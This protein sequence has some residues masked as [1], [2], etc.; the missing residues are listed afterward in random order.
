[1]G[2]ASVASVAEQKTVFIYNECNHQTNT[3]CHEMH[4]IQ[5]YL[6]NVVKGRRAWQKSFLCFQGYLIFFHF[7]ILIRNLYKVDCEKWMPLRN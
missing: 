7:L 3:M 6:T 2:L 4:Y 1:M 5:E